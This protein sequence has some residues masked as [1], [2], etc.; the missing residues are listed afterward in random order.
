MASGSWSAQTRIR[1]YKSHAPSSYDFKTWILE[2]RLSKTGK[3]LSGVPLYLCHRPDEAAGMPA[4]H[5]SPIF[6]RVSDYVAGRPCKDWQPPC[7]ADCQFTARL[8]TVSNDV[9]PS[10]HDRQM[11]VS[12]LFSEYLDTT[13]SPYKDFEGMLSVHT[14]CN[15]LPTSCKCGCELVSI[16]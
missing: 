5:V 15:C 14:S 8:C 16:Q 9:Y 12:E 13:C 10:E 7:R 1:R 3:R 2:Q 6:G 11:A 4:A